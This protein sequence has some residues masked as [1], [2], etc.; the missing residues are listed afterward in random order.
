MIAACSACDA[1]RGSPP[2]AHFELFLDVK[3]NPEK[4]WKLSRYER[5]RLARRPRVSVGLQ[6]NGQDQEAAHARA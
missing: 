2:R 4:E 3:E 5:L 1:L 6:W